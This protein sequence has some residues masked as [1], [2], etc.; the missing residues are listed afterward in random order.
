MANK[1][2]NQITR[3]VT[4]FDSNDVLP[5]GNGTLGDGKMPKDTLLEL[6][7]Q[8]AL[9]GRVAPTFIPNSTNAIAGNPYV[10]DGNVYI[11]KEDYT[12]DWDASKFDQLPLSSVVLKSLRGCGRLKAGMFNNDLN[13]MPDNSIYACTDNADGESFSNRPTTAIKQFTVVTISPKLPGGNG[14]CMVQIVSVQNGL[15]FMRSCWAPGSWSE[16]INLSNV[17]TTVHITSSPSAP[18][19]DLDTYPKNSVALYTNSGEVAHSPVTNGFNVFTFGIDASAL[20]Q[21]LASQ[22]GD[23]F[24]RTKWGSWT[25]W[26]RIT[27]FNLVVNPTTSSSPWNDLD[28]YPLNSAVLVSSGESSVSHKPSNDSFTCL[29][30]G[31]NVAALTQILSTVKRVTWIRSKWGSTWGEWVQVKSYLDYNDVLAAFTNIVCVGDSLT[32]SQVYTSENGS[33][34]AYKP[35]PSVL[36]TITG[37]TTFNL[38]SSGDDAIASWNRWKNLLESKTNALAIVYLGTNHGFTD[39]LDT[40]APSGADPS[41]WDDTTNTGCYALIINKLQQL[42]YKVL[43]IKP[44]AVSSPGVLSATQ[45]VVDDAGQRFGCTVV[46]PISNSSDEYH[47]WPDRSGRNNTHMN[48]LGYSWFAHELV[49]I[50][51]SAGDDMKWIIPS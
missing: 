36:G 42:G 4:S 7:A 26:T 43:L 22:S 16:W 20:T 39:T 17:L 25:P 29:T 31:A 48:D 30:L 49:R 15:K 23:K 38:G 32:Y 37:A 14:Y 10:F 28:N 3:V 5:I 44:W 24:I 18:Y 50:V 35:W 47:F 34:Q 45:K 27:D 11:A 8:N 46:G 40:D 9:A 12:G 51:S 41:T 19:D 21:I 13:S 33:R 6:T 2:F 1:R